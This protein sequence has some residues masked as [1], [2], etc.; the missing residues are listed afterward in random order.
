[1]SIELADNHVIIPQRANWGAQKP[2][3][4]RRWQTEI[5]G[6][7]TG[8]ED[9]Q[10]NAVLPWR[11]IE[12]V[13]TTKSVEDTADLLARLNLALR[14][15]KAAVP[16]WGRASSLREAAS[17]TSV[18]LAPGAYVWGVDDWLFLSRDD[19]W[20]ARKVTAVSGSPGAGY[21]LTIA[22]LGAEFPAGTPV[23]RMI[24][25]MP[26]VEE[27]APR[28]PDHVNVRIKVEEPRGLGTRLEPACGAVVCVEGT[29]AFNV[30]PGPALTIGPE[31]GCPVQRRLSWPALEGA[32]AYKVW[33][34]ATATGPWTEITDDLD[35]DL[36]EGVYSALVRVPYYRGEASTTQYYSVT[37]VVGGQEIRGRV[38]SVAKNRIERLMRAIQER[39]HSSLTD[40][41]IAAESLDEFISWPSRTYPSAG[42]A[43]DYPVN[44]WYDT[45]LQTWDA[46]NGQPAGTRFAQLLDT[47]RNA[48]L[49]GT[50]TTG[51]FRT[52][53]DWLIRYA[54]D[55]MEDWEFVTNESHPTNR[56]TTDST[57]AAGFTDVSWPTSTTTVA[58][59]DAHLDWCLATLCLLH[60][61]YY[62]SLEGDREWRF[63]T[64]S[65]EDDC[66]G[67]EADAEA[68]WNAASFAS[69]GVAYLAVYVFAQ[70]LDND[71]DPPTTERAQYA[72]R[73]K[74]T[75][76]LT[77]IVRGTPRLFAYFTKN[78]SSGQYA[79]PD[80][81]STAPGGG[82]LSTLAT[83]DS[84]WFPCEGAQESPLPG[85]LWDTRTYGNESNYSNGLACAA[86]G[87][88]DER[89]WFVQ[90]L[91][92]GVHRS[93][94]V[95][96]GAWD[97]Y[98]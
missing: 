58:L 63:G 13:P 95:E 82:P 68:A 84:V 67:A 59:T 77:N 39:R 8:G 14:A 85:T 65:T 89:G 46:A 93:S 56:Y 32:A 76:D 34:A 57:P 29:G 54:V 19:T 49:W 37:A 27:V 38:R 21:T 66:A 23:H 86:V 74:E 5:A 10:A 70:T 7:L 55:D 40:A 41:I 61:H 25:G 92:V 47:C 51:T 11:G 73:G 2:R 50:G 45:E 75:F 28:S 6:G 97:N 90:N 69:I 81:V 35:L 15:G 20:R 83:Y 44:G 48:F 53:Y 94:A 64:G 62:E 60:T 52:G 80:F 71:P 22:S 9:R 42:S 16:L 98:A 17:G 43:A 72:I 79:E 78:P 91:L 1:V 4:T 18:A 31:E 30:C 33:A 24:L 12:Y 3:L 87:G 36:D 26:T 96:A 88:R